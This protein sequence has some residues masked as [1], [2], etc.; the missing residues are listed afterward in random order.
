MPDKRES[1][2]LLR[3]QEELTAELH[4][5]VFVGRLTG[6]GRRELYFYTS[7]STSL[8]QWLSAIRASNP[9]R[10]FGTRTLQDPARAG[11]H[12]LRDEAVHAFAD[13]RTIRAL[14]SQGADLRK[15]H[16][17]RFYLYF[18]T[19][20]QAQAA[21]R[22]LDLDGWSEYQGWAPEVRQS[23]TPDSWLL[24]VT[25]IGYANLKATPEDRLVLQRVARQFGGV[26]DGWEA[27]VQNFS[28]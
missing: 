17:L 24:L 19:E 6:G 12:K 5:G 20:G 26:Y 25:F 8:D 1:E 23:G 27:S 11:Y 14:E 15:K 3:L 2:V 10:E 28:L 13:V 9:D 16:D 22:Q 7:P 18:P 21:L 4:E